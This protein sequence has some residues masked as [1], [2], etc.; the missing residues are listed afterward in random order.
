[1]IDDLNRDFDLVDHID[2]LGVFQIGD[3]IAETEATIR[4]LERRKAELQVSGTVGD[5]LADIEKDLRYE[6]N[7]LKALEAGRRAMMGYLD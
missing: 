6:K 3:K 4:K 7:R 5:E 2:W 1:M